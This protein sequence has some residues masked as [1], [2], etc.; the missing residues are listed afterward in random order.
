M[1][2]VNCCHSVPL[3]TFLPGQALVQQA[4]AGQEGAEALMF[5][6]QGM[7]LT[8]GCF[9]QAPARLSAASRGHRGMEKAS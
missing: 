6:S 5:P 2:T 7:G 4:P 1:K 3:S 8:A 9:L